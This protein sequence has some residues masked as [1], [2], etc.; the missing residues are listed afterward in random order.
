VA[1]C[2]LPSASVTVIGP[3]APATTWLLVSTLPSAVRTTPL[4]SPVPRARFTEMS[5]VLGVVLA[6]AAAMLP[7]AR[8]PSRP[9]WAPTA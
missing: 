7:D 3:C 9:R 6:A 1:W 4:P 5:T 2:S 8:R